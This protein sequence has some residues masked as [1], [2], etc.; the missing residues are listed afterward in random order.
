MKKVELGLVIQENRNNLGKLKSLLMEIFEINDN[1]AHGMIVLL[2]QNNFDVE[3]LYDQ[4]NDD[5]KTTLR[6]KKW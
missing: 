1:A 4:L 6:F 5:L 2:R 3:K